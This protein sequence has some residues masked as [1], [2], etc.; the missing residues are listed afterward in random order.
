MRIFIRAGHARG[1]AAARALQAPRPHRWPAAKRSAVSSAVTSAPSRGGAVTSASSRR[2]CLIRR[3]QCLIRRRQCLIRRRQCLIRRRQCI[4]RRRQCLI[5]RRQ[6]LIRSRSHRGRHRRAGGA[7]LPQGSHGILSR[8]LGRDDRRRAR[9]LLRPT[10]RAPRR[11]AAA[12]QRL[13]LDWASTP[14]ASHLSGRPRDAC[15][16]HRL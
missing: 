6:R 12:V 15:K 16:A 14:L 9:S 10:R 11:Q 7:L 5:R 13:L 4:I 8:P 3:R 2:G 1:A